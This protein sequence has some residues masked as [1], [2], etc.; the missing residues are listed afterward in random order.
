[1]SGPGPSSQGEGDAPRGSE[2]Y[3]ASVRAGI[4]RLTAQEAFAAQ[5]SGAVI[6]DTRTSEQRAQSRCI[7]GAICIDR[8]VLEWRLDP[9]FPW[10]IPEA[11]GW[12]TTYIVM[13]RHG[14]SSSVAAFCLQRLGLRNATDVIGG[15]DAWV[16][17]GLPTTGAPPDVRS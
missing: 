14:F 12:D 8:T 4:V 5:Q 3:L 1:M 16:A 13:C 7:P 6:I 10:R 2:A 15:Y 9:T 11:T 17:A